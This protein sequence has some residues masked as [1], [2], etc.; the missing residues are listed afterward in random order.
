MYALWNHAAA[1]YM[2]QKRF[3]KW[4]DFWW[5]CVYIVILTTFGYIS[6]QKLRCRWT[7]RKQEKGS[8]FIGCRAYTYIKCFVQNKIANCKLQSIVFF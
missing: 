2:A 4:A 6:A 7:I 1:D 5:V 3:L 8:G